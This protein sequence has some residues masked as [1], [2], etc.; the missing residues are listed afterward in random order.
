M[1]NS[2]D[3]VDR[4]INTFFDFWILKPRRFLEN[5]ACYPQKYLSSGQFLFVSLSIKFVLTTSY[6]AIIES[7]TELPIDAKNLVQ[8]DLVIYVAATV[9]NTIVF[10]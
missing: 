4:Y 1:N 9:F 3:L 8:I 2:I 6:F 7:S 10:Y 5:L